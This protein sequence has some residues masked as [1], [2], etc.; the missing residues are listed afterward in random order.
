[1]RNIYD[2]RSIKIVI[3]LDITGRPKNLSG[4]IKKNVVTIQ[5]EKHVP[6]SNRQKRQ[7]NDNQEKKN[8]NGISRVLLKN[9][10]S[11]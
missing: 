1:M 9:H 6:H 11:T 5:N 8:E 2:W 7:S 10:Y 4:N 3:K